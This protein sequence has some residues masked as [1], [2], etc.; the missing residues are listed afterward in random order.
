MLKKLSKLEKL[1]ASIRWKKES[2]SSNNKVEWEKKIEIIDHKYI[3]SKFQQAT[4]DWIFNWLLVGFPTLSLGI[5]KK[6]Y[7]SDMLLQYHDNLA[8]Y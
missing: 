4:R 3:Y 8:Q 5:L 2:E 6:L 7:S 1:Q